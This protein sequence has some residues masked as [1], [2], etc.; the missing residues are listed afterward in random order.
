MMDRG[1]VSGT[2]QGDEVMSDDVD[3]AGCWTNLREV[4]LEAPELASFVL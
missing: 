3:N 1:G 2:V 4:E